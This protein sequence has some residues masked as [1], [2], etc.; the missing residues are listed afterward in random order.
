MAF[1][2]RIIDIKNELTANKVLIIYGPR[3]IGKSTLLEHFLSEY[4][5][6]YRRDSGGNVLIQQL[7][8]SKDFSK[9]LPYAQGY[10]LIALDEAQDIPHIGEALKILFDE[11]KGVAIIATGSSSFNLSQQVGEPLTGRKKTVTLYPLSQ[12]ELFAL[13]NRH[14]LGG[15]LEQFLIFGGYPDVVLAKTR[16]EKIAVLR[17]LVQSYVF[18]DV[19]ALGRVR[20]SGQLIDLVKLLAFQVGNEVSVGKLAHEVGANATTTRRYLDL[21]EQAFVIR[22]I[23]GYGVN[24]H[25]E[26]TSKAKYYFIDNGIRNGIIGQ[27]NDLSNRND[28]GALFE[29]FIVMERIKK[30]AYAKEI[31]SHYFWR[32]YDGQEVDMVE[33]RPNEL[34]AIE[35]K[36]SARARVRAPKAWQARY[37]KAD[38]RVVTKENYLEFVLE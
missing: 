23:G 18:K 6:K 25:K 2:Q 19:L 36:W 3:Q 7:L 13:Y 31:V 8:S 15:Q 20:G 34:S 27:W 11:A 30:T 37:P 24:L 22:K 14:E 5:G 38:Y 12:Q 32:T 1:I 33:E 4:Q 17:D 28:I 35:I 29:N 16:D 9:I 10:D 26:V 21:L